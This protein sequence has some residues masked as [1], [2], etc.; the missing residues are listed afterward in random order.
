MIRILGINTKCQTVDITSLTNMFSYTVPFIYEHEM[1]IETDDQNNE[2]MKEILETNSY[3]FSLLSKSERSYY[4]KTF[5]ALK[6]ERDECRTENKELKE[7]LQ[8]IREMFEPCPD[9]YYEEW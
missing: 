3:V 2:L 5:D 1:A 8:K 6:K 7:K 4:D 9:D